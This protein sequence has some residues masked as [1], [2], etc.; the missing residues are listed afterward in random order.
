MA[1]QNLTEW[2]CDCKC[3]CGWV[4]IT[5]MGEPHR[6]AWAT[7]PRQILPAGWKQ[8]GSKYV[9]K[10]CWAEMQQEHGIVSSEE[11]A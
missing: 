2:H 9:C 7:G 4:E 10:R 1:S 3:G 5:E 8:L 11:D 6:L